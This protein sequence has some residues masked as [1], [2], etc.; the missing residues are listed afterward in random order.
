[1]GSGCSV[2]PSIPQEQIKEYLRELG[3][4]HGMPYYIIKQI[5]KAGEFHGP[6]SETHYNEI[7]TIVSSLD[8][9]AKWLEIKKESDRKILQSGRS[10]YEMWC[11]LNATTVAVM[12]YLETEGI[13]VVSTTSNATENSQSYTILFRKK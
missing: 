7:F 1:M 3:E 2:I 13:E 9:K 6:W 4:K 8:P 12:N 5:G 10:Y 11:S